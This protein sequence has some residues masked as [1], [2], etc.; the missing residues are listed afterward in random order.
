VAEQ[1]TR[2]LKKKDSQ[3]KWYKNGIKEKYR[4]QQAKFLS[5]MNIFILYIYSYYTY[6]H[7][8]KEVSLPHPVKAAEHQK[9]QQE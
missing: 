3:I 5:Y 1:E 9:K 7:I 4:V 6:I 8:K 2:F